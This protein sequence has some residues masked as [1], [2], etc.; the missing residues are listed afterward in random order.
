MARKPTDTK[1]PPV[2]AMILGVGS[3]A[4]SI[5]TA[6]AEAGAD[7]STYLTRNYGHFSPTLVGKTFSRDAFPSPV[8]LLRENKIDVVIPQSIDWATQPWAEDLAKSGVGIFS[9]TGEAMRIERERDF[10]REL[11]AKFKIPFPKSFVASNRIEAEKILAEH[12]QPFVLKNPLCSPTSPIHTVMCETVADTRA[13]LRNVNYAEGV[14]LQEYLGRA[15]AGHIALVSGGEI[16]SLVTNQEYKYA[17]NG[18][19]G[20]VAGAPLGGLVERDENDKYGLAR[21]LIHPLL[22]WLRK[23]NY[24][25][26]IQVTAIKVPPGAPASCR[27]VG[28]EPAGKMPALPGRWHVIEYNIRIGVTSGPMILRML[29]NPAA[30]VLATARNEKLKL[31]FNDKLNFGCSLTLAGYGYPFTQVRGPQLP[32][33]VDG[34]FDCDVWWNEVARGADSGLMSTG[35]RIADV[36]ALAPELDAA[37]AKAYTNIRKIRVVGSYFRTDVGESLWPPGNV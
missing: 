27:P 7:V 15:E 32:L 4:H 8:P 20:I 14:F 29:K 35:H 23:V 3:F 5:G 11:C 9:P 31:E 10:A 17:F 37:I 25:G 18:N 24:H 12:P 34:Q 33:E 16:Y 19:L 26:P 1:N 6:L 13:W 36:I 2:A 21:E 22:P 28:G 30:V